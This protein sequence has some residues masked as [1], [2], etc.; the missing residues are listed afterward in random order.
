[1]TGTPDWG[2]AAL[3]TGADFVAGPNGT[4]SVPANS[5]KSVP[6]NFSRPGYFIDMAI[7]IANASATIPWAL[8][9]FVWKDSTGAAIIDIEHYYI[10]A[11]SSGIWRTCGKGPVRGQMLEVNVT[12]YDPTYAMTVNYSIGQ[13]TQHI[14]RDD[15]RTLDYSTAYI[16]QYGSYVGTGNG[17]AVGDMA[18]GIVAVQDNDTLPAHTT[19]KLLLPMYTGLVYWQF[20]ANTAITVSVRTPTEF[21]SLPNLDGD[22]PL[23]F[24]TSLTDVTVSLA[25]PRFPPYLTMSNTTASGIPLG[26]LGIMVENCS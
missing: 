10:P 13:N 12:N 9:E 15:W 2:G 16:P 7:S 8:V 26:W 17:L 14:S 4:L 21:S 18:T 22:A 3:A 24:D 23:W 25:H 5:T 20:N 19:W 6:L 11:A 1:M